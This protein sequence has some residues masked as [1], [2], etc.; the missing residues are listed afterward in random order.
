MTATAIARA[1]ASALDAAGAPSPASLAVVLS[2][3]AEIAPL[4][5]EH[6]GHDGPTDVLSFPLLSPSA[7]PRHPGQV[8]AQ[9]SEIDLDF[10]LP[11]GRRHLGD[12]VIS[13]ERAID[14]AA[15]GR[16]GQSGDVR[17]SAADELT[18]LVIHGTLHV[19]GWDHA[20]AD[21]GAAM[22][23]VEYALM[24]DEGGVLQR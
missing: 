12:I 20:D 5:A 3:D 18:L 2:D 8:V 17:W 10:V 4:N 22:R 13:V 9:T 7:Y 19:C 1:V 23:A 24:S 6:M 15:S 11:P 21:E 14:Q 16:G